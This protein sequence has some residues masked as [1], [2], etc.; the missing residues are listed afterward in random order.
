MPGRVNRTEEEFSMSD[1]SPIE[2]IYREDCE[3]YRHQDGLM[4]GRFQTAAVVE[5]A[6]LYLIY[7]D[8]FKNVGGI[9]RWLLVCAGAV[10]VFLICLLSLKDRS[11][12]TRHIERIKQFENNKNQ[13]LSTRRWPTGTGFLLMLCAVI[14]MNA[15]NIRL[16]FMLW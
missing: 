2:T 12:G 15:F 3:F 5:G 1:Q 7:S 6:I 9:E 11:D 13:P 16:L 4:W 8:N 10:L 14:L